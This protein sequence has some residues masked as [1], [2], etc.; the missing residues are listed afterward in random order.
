MVCMW[1]V[2][3]NFDVFPNIQRFSKAPAVTWW[4]I[5]LDQKQGNSSISS[6]II[7][8]IESSGSWPF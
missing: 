2:C 6:L 7:H 5:S 8:T 1:Y 3:G 4:M